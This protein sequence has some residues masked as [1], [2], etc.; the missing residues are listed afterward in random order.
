M[1]GVED[2]EVWAGDKDANARPKSPTLKRCN[3][4][5]SPD[6]DVALYDVANN[7]FQTVKKR[8]AESLSNQY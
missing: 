2:L 1:M 3:S 6:A 4:P 5:K 7:R 8:D